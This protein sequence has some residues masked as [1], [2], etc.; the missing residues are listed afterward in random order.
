[1]ADVF[2][3]FSSGVLD[4]GNATPDEYRTAVVEARV[5]KTKTD[6]TQVNPQC[7]FSDVVSALGQYVQFSVEIAGP[8]ACGVPSTSG[9]Q[10]PQNVGTQNASFGFL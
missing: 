10:Q 9:S 5:G 6:L 7:S 1:M 4:S 8:S 3:D 2:G